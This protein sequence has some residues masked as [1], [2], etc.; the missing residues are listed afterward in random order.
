MK[1]VEIEKAL[2]RLPLADILHQI[3]TGII[4]AEAPS[5]RLL[6]KNRVA[7]EIL[8][9]PL[10]Y[11]N[12]IKDYT[13]HYK[14]FD[15]EGKAYESQ[16]WPLSRTIMNG[17]IVKGEEINFI[18]EDGTAI[19]I[20][21]NSAPIYDSEGKVI[22]GIASFYDITTLLQ[23]ETLVKDSLQRYQTLLDTVDGIVWE[24]DTCFNFTFVS[25]KAERISGF[26]KEEWM[27]PNFWANHIFH[28]DRD[29]AV[30]FCKEQVEKALPHD[31][32]YR[33]LTKD[34]S[35]IWLRDI[36]SV[37]IKD[38]YFAG[39]RGIM[40]DVTENKRIAEL[41]GRSEERLKT[42]L[43]NEPEC[44]QITNTEGILLEINP[45]GLAMYEA[46]I[47][48]QLIGHSL[49]PLIAGPSRKVYQDFNERISRGEKGLLEYE[50]VALE[51]TRRWL[52]AHAV[53]FIHQETKDTH[54]LSVV[55]DITENK[56][57]DI[58]REELFKKERAARIGA[59]KSIHMRD[60][61]LSVASHE[62]KTPLTPIR[63]QIQLVLRDLKLVTN[64]IPVAPMIKHLE[65]ADKQFSRFLKLV[66]NL[67]DVSRISGDRLIL[68]YEKINLTNLIQ[69]LA[70]SFLTEIHDSG[71]TLE[72]DLE[73]NIIGH[74]D[75]IRIDQV[76]VNVISNAEKYGSGTQIKISLKKIVDASNKPI[77]VISVQDKGI[78]I[79]KAD[80]EKLFKKFERAA[81]IRHYGGLGLGL[82]ITRN[83]VNA[84]HGKIR[85]VSELGEGSTFI[86]ELPI[87]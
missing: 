40:V 81:S 60:D 86:I 24:A 10:P 7:E 43:E 49:Y 64:K 53:P 31:F 77:A 1:Y 62:L 9:K 29:H 70:H 72:L 5:G 67:L 37:V 23:A 42:I 48:N 80:Q 26:T 15:K 79:S 73:P 6:M 35:V 32:E 25:Q 78:G 18:R 45:A 17:E 38:G 52:E 21:V 56:K 68:A 16:D 51:G 27:R 55:R 87:N 54:I 11:V 2:S 8:G 85:V 57:M 74:W 39:L 33:M 28:E 63:M 83:I 59:E 71:C 20:K 61:F 82:Y 4:L 66:D 30:N 47:S 44:V 58:H 14:G 65:E 75:R 12:N 41:L 13:R 22:A 36:V 50:I 84:H 69:E 3:P 76:L 19:V 34:D 46:K